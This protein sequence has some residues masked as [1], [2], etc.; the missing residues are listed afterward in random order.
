VSSDTVADALDVEGPA[1]PPRQN[2]ELTFRAPWESRIFGITMA[3]F[4]RGAFE[5]DEFRD[6]L[7]DEIARSDRAERQ[8]RA[9]PEISQEQGSEEASNYY[10]CWQSAF[11]RLLARKGLCGS[12]ELNDRCTVFA[13]RPA[14]HDHSHEH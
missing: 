9:E 5:W 14:G 3:L 4:K 8:H 13:A 11:E 10:V 6:F 2:G 7:I 12:A 1:A